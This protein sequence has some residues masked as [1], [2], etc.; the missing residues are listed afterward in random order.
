[1]EEEQA[2]RRSNLNDA[3]NWGHIKSKM[4]IGNSNEIT[5]YAVLFR[6]LRLRR[7]HS[8]ILNL[9]VSPEVAR[10]KEGVFRGSTLLMIP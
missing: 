5:Y 2:F 4:H 10:G 9:Q 3:F 7:A 8:W 1:M 6:N